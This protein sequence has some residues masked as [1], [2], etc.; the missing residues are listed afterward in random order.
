MNTGKTLWKWIFLAGVLAL[1]LFAGIARPR[2][3]RT[4][5]YDLIM[6]DPRMD[7]VTTVSV[8]NY[9]DNSGWGR[10]FSVEDPRYEELYSVP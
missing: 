10:S 8:M 6:D 1:L 3:Q 7:E 2:L 9:Y 4:N 5:L